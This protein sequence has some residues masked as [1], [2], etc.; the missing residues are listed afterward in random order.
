M[1]LTLSRTN[2]A[3]DSG[4]SARLARASTS[5]CQRTNKIYQTAKAQLS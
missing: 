5:I 4:S 2:M 3:V 1:Q